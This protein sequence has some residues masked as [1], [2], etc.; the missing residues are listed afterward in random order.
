MLVNDSVICELKA[1][2]EI[3]PADEAQLINYLR[4]S[5]I[6][7]GLLLNFGK[8]PELKRKIYDN[9]KKAWQTSRIYP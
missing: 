5:N 3:F 9:E 7:V 8:Q 6:E 1:R 2:D 4:A